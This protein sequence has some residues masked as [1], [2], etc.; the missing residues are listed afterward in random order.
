MTKTMIERVSRTLCRLEGHPENI[1]FE[2]RP[3]WA[4]YSETAAKVLDEMR[5]PT[6]VMIE[7]GEAWRNHCSDTDSIYSEMIKAALEDVP[8]A[9]R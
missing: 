1:M 3:M 6:E 5:E 9:V 7:A 8:P 4:S 2:G